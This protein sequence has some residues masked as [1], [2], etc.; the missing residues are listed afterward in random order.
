MRYWALPLL[1]LAA[2]DDP[3]LLELP[4]PP[5][6]GPV[7]EDGTRPRDPAPYFDAGEP[8]GCE[9]R[10]IWPYDFPPV[11]ECAPGWFDE[12]SG[13]SAGPIG[14]T[15]EQCANG[16]DEDCNG[17]IDDG[18]RDRAILL[19]LDVSGSMGDRR[20]MITD[21]L[22]VHGQ[23]NVPGE[24]WALAVLG[25]SP[26]QDALPAWRMV[27]S[28]APGVDHLCAWLR[29]SPWLGWYQ[30]GEYVGA[31]SLEAVD[32][33]SWPAGHSRHIIAV[34]D[35]E[36]HGLPGEFGPGTDMAEEACEEAEA[37]YSVLTPS[38]WHFYWTSVVN[39]CG[40]ET[41]NLGFG[42]TPILD[43]LRQ[44]AAKGC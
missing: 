15:P 39:T 13:Q 4:P 44:A 26:D 23:A 1:L 5:E 41:F 18:A 42:V 2:C 35:E 27:A 20:G 40:G 14:P 29:T 28:F 16:L 32:G 3:R 25:A 38:H 17:V 24:Q 22:C 36:P 34:T 8:D 31:V 9:L 33:L 6:A 10:V 19:V 7:A 37:M 11:G 43:A 12:C 21:A 30:H